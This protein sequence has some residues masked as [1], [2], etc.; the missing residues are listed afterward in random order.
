MKRKTL[1]L[2]KTVL[3]PLSGITD[4][5]FR[6]IARKC[7]CE[8]AYTEMV[9]VNGIFFDNKKTIKMLDHPKED[10]PLGVQFVGQDENRIL[11][12]AKVC[13]EMGF[14]LIDLNA[15]CP[16]R[17]VVKGGKGSAL[18]KDPVKLGKIINHLVK[19]TALPVTVKIRIGWDT[20]SKNYIEVGKAAEDNG[21]SAICVH[22]RTQCQMYKGKP[23]HNATRELKESLSI[24]IFASGNIFKPEDVKEVLDFTGCDG[25]AVARGALGR[26]WIFKEIKEYL[27]GRPYEGITPQFQELKNLLR[28]HFLLCL[29]Y[30]GEFLAFKR[31]YKHTAWYLK[32]YKNLD[33]I[34]KEF[35]KCKNEDDFNFFLDRLELKEEKILELRSKD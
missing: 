11:R 3:A 32:R 18:L 13:E 4:V 23:D 29:E 28:E 9:D 20:E 1:Q 24:P 6:L 15:G 33:V 17:K 25:V 12:A 7:G 21:A 10:S 19:E 5:P 16:A 14:D 22:A 26:P 2:P 34:M 31:M 35:V 8:F 30:F 27:Q